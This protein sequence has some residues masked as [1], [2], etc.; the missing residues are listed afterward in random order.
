[1]KLA[2]LMTFLKDD[3]ER[4]YKHWHFYMNAANSITGPHRI[5][6]Q[7]FLLKQAS[8][9]MGHISQF[10]QLIIGLGDKP[11]ESVILSSEYLTTPLEILKHALKMEEEVIAYFVER[12]DQ[13]S[14]L[15]NDKINAVY[16]GLFLED[17]IL[18]SRADADNLKEMLKGF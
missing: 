10:Q 5:E 13:V 2:D 7:E 18:D 1:M 3:L 9:E 15:E 4:E 17:Q 6:M 8:S 14:A 12:L 11:R 16:I